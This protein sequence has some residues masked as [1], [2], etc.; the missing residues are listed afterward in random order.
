MLQLELSTLSIFAGLAEIFVVLSA[1]FPLAPIDSH[2]RLPKAV[3]NLTDSV[4]HI[5][6]DLDN[7]FRIPHR[8]FE[9]SIGASLALLAVEFELAEALHCRQVQTVPKGD[10]SLH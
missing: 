8:W 3:V 7:L 6:Y 9:C 4:V 10:P 1:G 5:S 2:R